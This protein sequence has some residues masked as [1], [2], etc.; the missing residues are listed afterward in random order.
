MKNPNC[1]KKNNAAISDIFRSDAFSNERMQSPFP[2]RCANPDCHNDGT[3]KAP[4]TP[5]DVRDYIWFCL[6][7]VREYN[8]GWNYF[9]GIDEAGMEDAIRKSTTWERPS[10]AFGTAGP[11]I[12]PDFDDPFGILGSQKNP[13][14]APQEPQLTADE[15]KAWAIFRLSPCT[16]SDLVKKRYKELA[17]LHHPDANGGSRSAE[18]RL[19]S[20]N[21]AY[22]IL[23]KKPV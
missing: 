8:K 12:T 7:H 17:K 9:E 5:R 4:R 18:S 22:A 2:E 23:K 3:Y 19:K 13:Q 1:M 21:W 15:K 14:D 6:D 20:I 11:K 10:W 16:D